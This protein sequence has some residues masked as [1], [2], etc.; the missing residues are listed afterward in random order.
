MLETT[1][2]LE[3]ANPLL[4]AWAQYQAESR[5]I[6]L[7]VLKGEALSRYGLRPM[8]TSSD[9]DVLIDPVAFDAY[10]DVVV[11]SG[12][13]EFPVSYSTEKFTTH[14]RT[15][16]KTGWP[17]SLDIHRSYPGFLR[18]PADVFELLWERRATLEIAHRPC[19]VPSR[20][21]S[22]FILALHSMR[23]SDDHQRHARELDGIRSLVL[24]DSERAEA[25]DLALRSG[26]S[27]SMQHVLLDLGV[28][29]PIDA[30]DVASAAYLQWRTKV[31]GAGSTIELWRN[32]LRESR[33]D[34]KPAVVW[35]ALWPRRKDFLIDHPGT[36]DRAWDVF[37]GRA[38]RLRDGVRQLWGWG[39]NRRVRPLP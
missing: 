23:S 10:L 17:N 15:F 7:L 35:R 5:G 25:Y 26:A 33:W 6:R 28:S 11:R 9:V 19:Q 32:L 37:I 24:T 27:L 2:G 14:S 20:V 21:A 38:V 18:D 31:A 30:N 12:W 39:L 22:A 29:V 4:A 3:A 13:S 8:R 34:Q 36:R 1:L 16:R